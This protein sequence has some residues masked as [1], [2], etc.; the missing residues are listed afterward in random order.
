M[1]WE[2]FFSDDYV[3]DC[4]NCKLTGSETQ[5]VYVHDSVFKYLYSASKGGSIYLEPSSTISILIEKTSFLHSRSGSIAGAVYYSGKG[6]YILSESC[7]FNCSGKGSF[8]FDYT[9]V[10]SG[11]TQKNE[12]L[13]SSYSCCKDKQYEFVSYRW[14]GKMKISFVN[15]SNNEAKIGSCLYEDDGNVTSFSSFANSS[16]ADYS[17]IYFDSSSITCVID[18]CNFIGNN[19]VST[20][21]GFL[22]LNTN[23]IIQN[24]CIF[25]NKATIETS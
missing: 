8:H 6:A 14:G 4:K 25:D 23:T 10:T 2:D 9:Y 13:D 19:Q 17:I 15:A 7:G 21:K 18:H 24:C 12:L 1:A 11:M 20:T 22:Y 3:I 5:N 16:S